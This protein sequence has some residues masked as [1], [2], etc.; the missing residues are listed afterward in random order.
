MLSYPGSVIS[1]INKSKYSFIAFAVVDL[2]ATLN[3]ASNYDKITDEE[4]EIKK[5]VLVPPERTL[6]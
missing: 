6:G 2:T 5:D 3:F 1:R 4:R